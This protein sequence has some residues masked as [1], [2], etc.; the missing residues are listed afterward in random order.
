MQPLRSEIRA[1]AMGAATVLQVLVVWA[2]LP[3][4]G[5]P[6]AEA[7]LKPSTSGDITWPLSGEEVQ[8]AWSV[9]GA[10]DGTLATGWFSFAATNG[11]SYAVDVSCL[12]VTGPTDAY[13]GGVFVEA[14][15]PWMI[16]WYLVTHVHKGSP[17][18]IWNSMYP[19]DTCPGIGESE[20]SDGPFNVASGDITITYVCETALD[21]DDGDPCTADTCLTGI[22]EHTPDALDCDDGDPCTSDA[23]ATGVGCTHTPPLDCDDEDPCTADACDDAGG[24][25]HSPI[26]GCWDLAGTSVFRLSASGSVRGYDVRCWLRCRQATSGTL[27]LDQATERYRMPGEV[28][29]CPLGGAVRI[30]DELGVVHTK[31]HQ[32]LS[33]TP[34]NREDIEQ[35]FESCL[36]SKAH[37]RGYRTSLRLAEDGVHLEG[38]TRLRAGYR[39][40]TGYG[41]QLPV[42][43]RFR[44]A[45]AGTLSASGVP[46]EPPPL[47][48]RE[49]RLP[50][51]ASQHEPKCVVR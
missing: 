34:E 46:V 40:G 29:S 21:C 6:A 38:R 44:T 41:V 20:P 16:G 2:S 1:V 42:S 5:L 39:V 45:F 43:V 15:D 47:R 8:T 4:V 3:V 10:I 28:V 27:V 23:C 25:G 26:D 48:R 35:A 33:L 11:T 37:V 30:P 19:G 9:E 24:C 50:E 22:C 32:R 17:D 49:A 18:Q 36:A 12:N 51:C 7:Q 31:K 13:F 14:T